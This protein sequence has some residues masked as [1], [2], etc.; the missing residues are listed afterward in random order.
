MASKICHPL[1]FKPKACLV[2]P[3]EP[4]LETPTFLGAPFCFFL[5]IF[6]LFF[7]IRGTNNRKESS[8]THVS[9]LF[10]Y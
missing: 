4:L 8:K 6:W 5:E 9:I 1:N 10:L 7:N 2:R 3:P